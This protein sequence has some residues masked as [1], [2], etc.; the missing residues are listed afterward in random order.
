MQENAESV[1]YRG[2]ANLVHASVED[3]YLIFEDQGKP[4]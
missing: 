2:I 3:L 1:Y 4:L